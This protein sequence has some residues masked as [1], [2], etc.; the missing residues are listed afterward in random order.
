MPNETENWSKSSKAI[1]N[2]NLIEIPDV[3]HVFSWS[4][5]PPGTENAKCTQ[6]HLHFGTSVGTLF[7]RFKGPNTIDDLIDALQKHRRDVWGP[8]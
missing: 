8:W 6:V 3:F 5:S 4:P 7:M 2:A 1:D